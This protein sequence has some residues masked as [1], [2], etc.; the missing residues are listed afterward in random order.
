MSLHGG[1]KP[2]PNAWFHSYGVNHVPHP[3]MRYEE[4]PTHYSN[5]PTPTDQA[6]AGSFWTRG[7]SDFSILDLIP[8]VGCTSR[9]RS[10][11]ETR[12][13]SATVSSVN[14]A[15]ANNPSSTQPNIQRVERLDSVGDPRLGQVIFLRQIHYVEGME[16][17]DLVNSGIYQQQIYQELEAL[18]ARG[19]RHIFGEGAYDRYVIN[20]EERGQVLQRL[21]RGLGSIS[22]SDSQYTFLSWF[23]AYRVFQVFHD[24]SSLHSV[25]S[26]EEAERLHSE[27]LERVRVGYER[28]LTEHEVASGLEDLDER[29]EDSAV[30]R[31]IEF[32]RTHPTETVVLVFGM[33]HDFRDNFE[34][35]AFRPQIRSVWWQI[36]GSERIEVGSP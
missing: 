16:R 5:T 2:I 7:W 34:R 27:T 17:R 20:R 25:T 24:D 12:A 35:A 29:S 18:H 4:N 30:F 3:E 6:L 22:L 10:A 21:P 31:I 19:I 23:S 26:R 28:G 13:R 15:R 32:L 36:Q 33:S 14:D 8:G 9:S 1:V 11:R